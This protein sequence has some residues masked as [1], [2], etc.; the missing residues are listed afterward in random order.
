VLIKQPRKPDSL[1]PFIQY[2]E[3]D[4]MMTG[5][6]H[7]ALL[8]SL[9]HPEARLRLLAA[10]ACRRSTEAQLNQALTS[11]VDD[12]VAQIRDLARHG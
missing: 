5:V 8:S 1:H 7:A 4:E 9:N 12:P 11:L 3:E 10:K 2:R 6:V